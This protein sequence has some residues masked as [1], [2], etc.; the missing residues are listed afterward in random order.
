MNELINNKVFSIQYFLLIFITKTFNHVK[1][2][3]YPKQYI[4]YPK[5]YIQIDSATF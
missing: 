4:Q 2:L 5:K 3:K 1:S